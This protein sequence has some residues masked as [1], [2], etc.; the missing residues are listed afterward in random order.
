MNKHVLMDVITRADLD[1]RIM[2]SDASADVEK[3]KDIVVARELL[4]RL[5]KGVQQGEQTIFL[6][7][8]WPLSTL[9]LVAPAIGAVEAQG[10]AVMYLSTDARAA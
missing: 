7:D 8:V 2:L 5:K 10:I 6:G 1:L 4:A 9:T 3:L